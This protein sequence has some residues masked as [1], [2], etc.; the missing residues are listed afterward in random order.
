MFRTGDLGRQRTN[1][2]LEWLGRL[3]RQFKLRG[4]RIEAGEIESLLVEHEF[5]DD[6]LIRIGR[7]RKEN[8]HLI[9]YVIT[10]ADE[11]ET[12]KTT[13]LRL[14]LK[15]RLPAF[16][17]PAS[18]IFLEELPLT[19]NGKIDW[20]AL[21][22]PEGLQGDQTYIAPRTSMEA[23][24]IDI[25][26]DLLPEPGKIGIYDNFFELGGHSLLLLAVADRLNEEQGIAVSPALLYTH[27]QPARLA[28]HLERLVAR[29][30]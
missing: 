5:V 20:S 18:F 8:P 4:F 15:T 9:A 13:A 23:M 26:S 14:K 21:P 7:D 24:I 30:L 16:M 10:D 12:E 6:A 2:D 28:A 11:T 17:I 3:D 22:L 1:G 29:D 27:P 19:L 25:W